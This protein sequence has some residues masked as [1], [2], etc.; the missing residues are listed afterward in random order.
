[1]TEKITMPGENKTVAKMPG[2]WV[3][4]RLGKRVLRPG[5]KGLTEKM[6]NALNIGPQD[7]VIEFAPGMGFTAQLC[8]AKA[9]KEY[10]AIEQSEQAADIVRKYL[11][12]VNQICLV[13]NAQDTGLD[14]QTAS[15]IYG[16]AMLT[17]QSE[18][19]KLDIIGEASRLLKVGGRYGIH[20][21]C[22]VP[23]DIDES[24]KRQIQKDIAQAIQ[25]PAKPITPSEW[26]THLKQHGF[27]VEKTHL[28]PMHLLEPKRMIDD[29][30]LLGFLRVA[31]NLLVD[32]EARKRVIGMRK[33]FRKHR[34]HLGAISLIAK[35]SGN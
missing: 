27:E 2:H 5:G 12:S 4:A 34:K 29:E 10:T 31:K 28:A 35:K 17:M 30:G 32:K 1:M 18:N 15:V 14:K 26:E 16:E 25:A 13:G 24:T 21:L 33:V 11:N 9:P 8:L 23:D 22:I 7:S 20:E 6:I 19:K 3:L